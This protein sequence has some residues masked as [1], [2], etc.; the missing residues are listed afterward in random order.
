MLPEIDLTDL[1]NSLVESAYAPLYVEPL[2]GTGERICIG[3]V[4][5]CGLHTA[6]HIS[7]QAHRLSF[8]FCG[9]AEWLLLG[10]QWAAKSLEDFLSTHSLEAVDEWPA[11]CSV[12]VGPITRCFT[13]SID[14]VLNVA[15]MAHCTLHRFRESGVGDFRA[16]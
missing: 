7:D 3:A 11:I 2:A 5:T 16:V 4:A 9:K 6:V 12:T 8:L 13:P 10:L 15:L 14:A 1:R